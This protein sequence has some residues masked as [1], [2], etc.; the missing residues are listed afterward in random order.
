MSLTKVYRHTPYMK[1][2]KSALGMGDWIVLEKDGIGTRVVARF[3]EHGC[4]LRFAINY[5][6]RYSRA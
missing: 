6:E 4:A 5:A 1:V 2:R 3:D